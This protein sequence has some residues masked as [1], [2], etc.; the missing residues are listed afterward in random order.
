M[1]ILVTGGAGFI[2]SHIVD[3]YIVAGHKVAVIDN[4]S[5]GKK[6]N[7]N[8]REKFYEADIR[9]ARKIFK[10]F[11]AEKPEIVNHHAALASV[12]E[13]AKD[14]SATNDVNVKG[15][16]NLLEASSQNSVRKFIFAST[17]GAL[18]GEYKNHNFTETYSVKP[19]SP[20]GLSKLEAEKEIMAL[21]GKFNFPYI[22]FRYANV[23]GPRQN[24]HGEAGI[25]AIFC[26]LIS[27]N[28]QPTMYSADTTRD[29]L[30]VADIVTANIIALTKGDNEI[31]NLGT[32]KQITNQEIFNAIAR[33]FNYSG[34][35]KLEPLRGGELHHTALDA[36]KAK[37][38]LNWQAVISL[39][40][41]IKKIKEWQN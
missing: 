37:R 23:F 32:G 26:N 12:T 25:V 11:R 29:Y 17:G 35:P 6:E 14:P 5:T 36:A 33:V 10:I 21:A 2:G 38:E 3:A 9:D 40:A 18:Y 31:Y 39:A 19:I 22:I 13:S 28:K 8:P 7:L 27:Q 41:G 4:F 24:P 15:T 1:K 34:K 16:V 20:Y 30:Y